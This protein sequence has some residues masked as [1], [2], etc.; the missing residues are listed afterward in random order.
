MRSE[1]GQDPRG[2]WPA[3]FSNARG[4][5]LEQNGYATAIVHA[6]PGSGKGGGSAEDG[7]PAFHRLRTLGAVIRQLLALGFLRVDLPGG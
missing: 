1:A 3:S 7:T 4:Y 2:C 5:A 6:T